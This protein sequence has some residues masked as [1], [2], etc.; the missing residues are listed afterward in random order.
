MEAAN[1]VGDNSQPSVIWIIVKIAFV[2]LIV[3]V[4]LKFFSEKK[5]DQSESEEESFVER[6]KTKPKKKKND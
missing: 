6:K 2:I 5:S 4:G 1:P 3:F